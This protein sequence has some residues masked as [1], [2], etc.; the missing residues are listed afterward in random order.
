VPFLNFR[1]LFRYLLLGFSGAL[2]SSQKQKRA[3]KWA[4]TL[5]K[6]PE[7]SQFKN[8]VAV[9]KNINNVVANSS[10]SPINKEIVGFFFF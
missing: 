1:Y 7:I 4:Q 3:K 10:Q 2:G 9:V 5:S 8:H 6:A